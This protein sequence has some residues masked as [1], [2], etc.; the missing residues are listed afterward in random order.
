[1]ST[2][3]RTAVLIL[4]LV[5]TVSTASATFIF[6]PATDQIFDEIVRKTP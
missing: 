5:G 2:L 4:T 1:M 6:T 3:L